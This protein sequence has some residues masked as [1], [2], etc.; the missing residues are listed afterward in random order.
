ML[1]ACQQGVGFLTPAVLAHVLALIGKPLPASLPPVIIVTVKGAGLH[2]QLAPLLHQHAAASR[3]IQ[4]D[5]QILAQTF[6]VGF[7]TRLVL[8][9]NGLNLPQG[10][11]CALPVHQIRQ[12]L[13]G[14]AV[15]EFQRSAV[16]IHF[17]I[18]EGLYPHPLCL[19]HRAAQF[20]Q[21]FAH[22][23]R[24]DRLGQVTAGVQ[25]K[26]RF[27]VTAEPG[28]KNDVHIGVLFFQLPGQLHA[29]DVRHLHIQKGHIAA[30]VLQKSQRILRIEKAVQLCLRR[31]LLDGRHQPFQRQFLIVHCNDPHKFAP[32]GM[33]ISA[34]VPCPGALVMVSVPP[35][36]SRSR[37]R[38]LRSPKCGLPSSS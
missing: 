27:P 11:Q 9:Q 35:A 33:R 10:T 12:H 23:V 25:V 15:P 30:I 29:A 17:K 26:G 34:V 22:F 2:R 5:L 20:C 21:L 16:H 4:C 1:I 32:L 36:I 14:A 13:L 3:L 28:G 19:R 8:K 38:A 6:H 7:V 31:S 37:S 24:R 18:P